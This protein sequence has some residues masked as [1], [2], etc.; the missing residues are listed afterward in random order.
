MANAERCS[1]SL[2]PR[3]SRT[4]IHT[5]ATTPVRLYLDNPIS[6]SNKSPFVAWLGYEES[7]D[8]GFVVAVLESRQVA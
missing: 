3:M 4:C 1:S 5:D 8:T 7:N 2:P 6:E